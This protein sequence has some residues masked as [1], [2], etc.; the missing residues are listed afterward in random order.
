[1]EEERIDDIVCE[2]LYHDGPDRHVD[3]HEV[4]T[5]FIK[6]MQDGN[7]ETWFEQYKS[8]KRLRFIDD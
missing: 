4:L 5:D 1:M 6:A 3:G 8:N 7:G 2:I